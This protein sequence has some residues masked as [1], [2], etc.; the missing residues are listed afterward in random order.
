MNGI[1]GRVATI[2][3]PSPTDGKVWL[4]IRSQS[5]APIQDYR[6]SPQRAAEIAKAWNAEV[7]SS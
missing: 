7:V 5:W 3:E 6:V 1:A 2:T 4:T